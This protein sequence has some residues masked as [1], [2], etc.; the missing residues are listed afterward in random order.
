LPNLNSEVK[1]KKRLFESIQ[2]CSVETLFNLF[3]NSTVESESTFKNF[4]AFFRVFYFPGQWANL[5]EKFISRK[6][7]MLIEIQ[8]AEHTNAQGQRFLQLTLEVELLIKFSARNRRP[9]CTPLR[10]ALTTCSFRTNLSP[11]GST[12]AGNLRR[13][14]VE[15]VA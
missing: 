10:S 4:G 2:I 15:Q 1:L 7:I 5:Q 9:H 13:T 14:C 6:R 8:N 11:L 3:H 12:E